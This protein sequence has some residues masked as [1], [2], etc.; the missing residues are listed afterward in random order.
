MPGYERL[1]RGLLYRQPPAPEPALV[2]RLQ[3]LMAPDVKRLESVLNRDL[4]PI[5]GYE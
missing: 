4:G 1:N 5:W 2:A 3:R